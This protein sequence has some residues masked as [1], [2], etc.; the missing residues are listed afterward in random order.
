MFNFI[1]LAE[2]RSGEKIFAEKKRNAQ[3]FSITSWRITVW[4]LFKDYIRMK[5]AG[6]FKTQFFIDEQKAAIEEAEG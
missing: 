6:I 5:K 3:G 2:T 1:P 4:F